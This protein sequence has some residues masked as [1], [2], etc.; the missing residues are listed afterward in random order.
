MVSLARWQDASGPRSVLYQGYLSEM[1]VPYMDADYGWQIPHLL[2]Y[3]RVRRRRA[4]PRPCAPGVDCPATAS[5][6]PA[7][8]SSEKGEPYTTPN[9]L[10]VFERAGGEPAWRH[11]EAINQT[12]EGRANVEL[13]VRM[14]AT[15]GNYDYLFDWV[16][17]DAAEIEVRVGATGIVALKGVADTAHERCHAQPRTRATAR[18]SRPTWWPSTTTTTSTSASTSTWTA[19]ATA[20]TTT[21]I[22][23]RSCRPSRRGEA[24]TWWSPRSPP[25]RRRRRSTRTADRRRCGWSTRARTNAA[26]N[27]VSYEVLAANHARLLLDPQDWPARR[28][29]YLQHDLWVTPYEPEERYAGG[30]YALGSRGRRRPGGVG[31]PRSADP[32]S[33]HRGVGQHRDAS[34]HPRR[35]SAG[36]ADALALVH[37]AAA[38]LLR[39]QPGPRS[40]Q[41]E[42]DGAD[43]QPRQRPAD[44]R[45]GDGNGGVAPIGVAL[46]RDGQHRMGEARPEVSSRVD[47]IPGRAAERHSDAPHQAADHQR[48][49]AGGR[50]H[51]GDAGRKIAV[52]TTARTKVAMISLARLAPGR[53]TAGAVQNVPSLMSLSSVSAQCGR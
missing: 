43:E 40:A 46:A 21:S 52:A 22:V 13:V 32:Q 8:F 12:Y 31:G 41:L 26:G 16:F 28:A 44:Q 36:N 45:P 24:S 37:A 14:A 53:R 33:R 51:G 10:C 4:R 11:F 49:E 3:R 5:Y 20:S 19:R 6:L 25:P 30:E 42:A 29:R 1:F 7:V 15:I 38:Q 48:A 39:S 2:R 35:G 9:A 17:N 47:G 27:P 18:W 23:R 34:P 50:P